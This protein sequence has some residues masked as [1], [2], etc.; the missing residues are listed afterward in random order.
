[1]TD[2]ATANIDGYNPT[3]SKKPLNPGDYDYPIGPAGQYYGDQPGYDYVAEN[4]TYVP[5]KTKKPGALDTYGPIFGTGLAAGG[6]YAIAQNPGGFFNGLS[7]AAG[8]LNPF[9]GGTAAATPASTAAHGATAATHSGSGLIGGSPSAVSAAGPM[10]HAGGEIIGQNADGSYIF[11]KGGED[12]ISGGSGLLG[13]STGTIG[14]NSLQ[15]LGPALAVEEYFR[16]SVTQHVVKPLLDG[17]ASDDDW[18]KGALMS[19]P[20]T[21]W[22]VPIADT[23]GIGIG[24][25]PNY[26]AGKD[27]QNDLNAIA[28]Y[29][30]GGEGMGHGLLSFDKGDGTTYDVTGSQ[31]RHDP[32]F[33]NYDQ[34]SPS[35]ESDI[36]AANVAAYLEGLKLG[37]KKFTDMAGMLAGAHK[38]GVSTPNLFKGVGLSDDHDKLYGQVIL[39]EQAG[40]LAHEDADKLKNGLDQSFGVGAYA[41]GGSAYKP[42]AKDNNIKKPILR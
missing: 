28:D 13:P 23:L 34:A 19:N 5:E 2:Y 4:D 26:Y 24:H 38:S 1:M 27:R 37:S 12:A 42:P 7:S 32:N 10:S 36:G 16:P 3:P 9:S 30:A 21:A 33:Y 15:T 39:D 6:A 8:H 31:Y 22:A 14:L 17:K 11:S 25:G 40:K 20:V 18:L 41:P 29:V 35:M